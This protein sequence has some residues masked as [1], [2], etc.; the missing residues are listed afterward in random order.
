MPD[1]AIHLVYLA[2]TAGIS[3]ERGEVK[4]CL[5]SQKMQDAGLVYDP[6]GAPYDWNLVRQQIEL[7]DGFVLLLGDSYGPMAPTGISYLHR[8]FV[9]AQSLNKPILAFARTLE[10]PETEEQRR[11]AG[12][13][14]II[15]QQATFKRWHLRDELLSHVRSA[16]PSYRSQ[17]GMGWQP[18][19]RQPIGAATI[20]HEQEVAVKPTPAPKQRTAI[21]QTISLHVV[22]D[23]YEAGNCTREE[24]M[25]PARLDQLLA[26]LRRLLQ[27][28][29]SEDRLRSHL[30]GLITNTVSERL[31]ERHTNAHAVDD[32]RLSRGQF[33]QIL[34]LW[35]QQGAIE[36]S[37]QGGRAQWRSAR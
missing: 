18:A 5:A 24:Q 8:E 7:A 25:L 1:N 28:G 36:M 31:L 14:Q 2:S 30:E 16:L 19:A 21:R 9:H 32:V 3:L 12:F 15:A 37:E 34:K 6:E 22:A 27:A 23:V 10:G 13:H 11:L 35:Q 33:Q 17:L 20:P 29:A 26:S 4:R